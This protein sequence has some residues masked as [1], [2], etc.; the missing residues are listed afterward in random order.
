MPFWVLIVILA[1]VGVLWFVRGRFGAKEK[2]VHVRILGKEARQHRQQGKDD[3]SMSTD[4][5]VRFQAEGKTIEL[6]VSRSMFDKAREN[7]EG[8]L[9]LKGDVFIDYEPDNKRPW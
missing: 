3:D 4:Y 2:N 7:D 5:M 1:V 8:M 9:T 6:L